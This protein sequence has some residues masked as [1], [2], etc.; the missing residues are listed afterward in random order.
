MSREEDEYGADFTPEDWERV[1]NYKINRLNVDIIGTLLEVLD[2]E[3][4]YGDD[5]VKKALYGDLARRIRDTKKALDLGSGLGGSV[6]NV[7]DHAQPEEMHAVEAHPNR[8]KALKNKRNLVLPENVKWVVHGAEI[9]DFLENN[10]EEFDLIN[11]ANVP[12]HD[13]NIEEYKLLTGA[14]APGGVMIQT[15]DTQLNEEELKKN[16]LEAAYAGHYVFIWKKAEEGKH[17]G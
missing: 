14:L 13:H 6:Q 5:G 16:G 1:D 15:G 11:I 2:T 7:V 9:N 3:A 12:E 17:D 8:V 4:E 10:E